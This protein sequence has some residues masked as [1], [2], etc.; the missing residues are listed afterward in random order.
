MIGA[1]FYIQI[2]GIERTT[3]TRSGWIIA[4]TPVVMALL[5]ALFLRERIHR[6]L[7]AGIVVSTAGILLLVSNGRMAQLDWLRSTGDWL[8]FAS[9]HTWAL[10]TVVRA[11]PGAR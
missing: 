1:H 7:A 6:G 10:Y 4:V 8:V 9:A 2:T 3:A 5:A 11:R